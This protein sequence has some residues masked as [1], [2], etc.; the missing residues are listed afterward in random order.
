MFCRFLRHFLSN[1]TLSLNKKKNEKNSR[2]D[3]KDKRHFKKLHYHMVFNYKIYM[4]INGRR[5]RTGFCF[6]LHL[7]NFHIWALPVRNG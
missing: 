1:L 3:K 2:K 5:K 4:M 7:I 6:L